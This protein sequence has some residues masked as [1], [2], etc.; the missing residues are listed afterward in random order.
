[1][2]IKPFLFAADLDGTLLPNTTKQAPN[3]CLERT[4]TLLQFLLSNDC[5]VC[6]ISGRHLALAREGIR[7]FNLP[8]P[9]YWV[10]NVGTEIYDQ[11]GR[12]HQRWSA[13]LGKT[14]EHDSMWHAISDLD[15]GLQPQE[16]EKQGPHKFSLY[17]PEAAPQKMQEAILQRLQA[18][19][20]NI[21]LI[22]SV[23][24]ASGKG[25]LDVLPDNAGKAPA[26][27]FLAAAHGKPPRQTFFAGDS[28]NDL[29]ALISGVCGAM[30]GNAPTDLR[31][32]AR[33]LQTRAAGSR[34]YIA[35]D[36]YGDGV[37]EGLKAFH[38]LPQSLIF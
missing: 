28:G 30:V 23:E 8:V 3:G 13:L 36:F 25:L 26:L 12:A 10:C 2:A 18:L 16:Q 15:A 11:F 21:H 38:L 22:H 4:H 34:L 9:S 37:I 1:M 6:Y 33:D 31:A 32:H 20:K 7:A 35:S 5:P 27:L 14:F 24:E 29:D 17:Y 19:R